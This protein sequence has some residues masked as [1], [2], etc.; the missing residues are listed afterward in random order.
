MFREEEFVPDYD[1]ID[2][3]DKKKVKE[4]E[5]VLID[6]TLDLKKLKILQAIRSKR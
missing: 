5:K 4:E 1:L 6:K 3:K 2:D